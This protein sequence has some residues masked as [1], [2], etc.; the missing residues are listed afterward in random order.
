V[1]A[2]W[3]GWDVHEGHHT[4]GPFNRSAAINQAS[5]SAGDWDV[6]VIADSDSFVGYEQL[7]QAIDGAERTGQLWLAYDVFMSLDKPM[8]D[9][10]LAGYTGPWEPG[11][12]LRLEGTCSSVLCVPRALW[13]RV[14]GF[15]EGFV[16][17]GAEDVAFWVATDALG[18]GFHRVP[19]PVWHLW[20]DKSPDTLEASEHRKAGWARLDRYGQ[21][22]R[23]PV[24]VA[25]LLAELGVTHDSAEAGS[26]RP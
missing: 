8:T 5:R 2:R 3:T 7:Q 26:H 12:E 16:G 24:K 25:A 11:V 23:D 10:I 9:R 13:D 17:W 19:G 22:E 14:G 4:E 6:A 1:R 18:G 20:H 15:D 21:C